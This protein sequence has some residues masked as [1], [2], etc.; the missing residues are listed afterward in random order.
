[1]N[2][3][4]ADLA[5]APAVKLTVAQAA[6]IKREAASRNK[7][8]KAANDVVESLDKL[9]TLVRTTSGVLDETAAQALNGALN[10]RINTIASAVA[11]HVARPASGAPRAKTKVKAFSLF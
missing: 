5:A 9:L 2:D 1:M 11:E 10:G 6:A 3:V 7:L 4:N 8:D